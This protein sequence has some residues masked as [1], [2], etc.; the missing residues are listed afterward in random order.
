MKELLLTA[1]RENRRGKGL[2]V[3]PTDRQVM[4]IWGQVDFFEGATAPGSTSSLAF[5]QRK[6]VQ[7]IIRLKTQYAARIFAGAQA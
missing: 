4:Q 3:E 6:S 7:S 1:L 5:A 2:Y